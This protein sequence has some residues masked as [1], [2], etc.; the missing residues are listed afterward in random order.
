MAAND[1]GLSKARTD[2]T[3][4]NLDRDW[5]FRG[6][7]GYGIARNYYHRAN[8]RYSKD[9]CN[10]APMEPIT[11]Q[12]LWGETVYVHNVSDLATW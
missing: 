8:R 3:E 1:R 9:L 5:G 12:R 10:V 6:A 4:W 11:V 7:K 2:V